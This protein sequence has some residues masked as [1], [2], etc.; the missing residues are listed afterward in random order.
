MKVYVVMSMDRGE[1]SRVY[2][3][4]DAAHK[5]LRTEGLHPIGNGEW[6]RDAS[7]SLHASASRVI[8][9]EVQS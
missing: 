9:Y 4:R 2:R 8:E 5:Y 3:T 7:D 1:P 6:G